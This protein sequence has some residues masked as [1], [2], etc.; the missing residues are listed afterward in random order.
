MPRPSNRPAFTLIELLVVMAIIAILIGLLLPAVQKVRDA[1]VGG[2]VMSLGLRKALGEAKEAGLEGKRKLLE[3]YLAE[4]D[5][6]RMSRRPGQRFGA[7]ARIHDAMEL[8]REVGLTDE[9]RLRARNI[10]IAALCL[11]DLQPGREWSVGDDGVWPD[12]LDPA[13]RRTARARAAF[14][15]V[16]QPRHALHG[17]GWTSPDGR[18]LAVSTHAVDWVWTRPIRVW[19]VDGAKQKLV[20]EQSE[21]VYEEGVAFRPDSREV[22][23]GHLSGAVSLHDLGTGKR[24]AQLEP[25]PG[26][27][28]T[29]A[30]HPRLPRL[31]VA[32][33]NEVTIW[34][35]Q[36]NRRLI[37]MPQPAAAIA[38]AWHPRGHRLAIA[39]GGHHIQLWDAEAGR[40]VTARWHG[41]NNDGT[42]LRFS[43]AGDRVFS[44]Q[45]YG[46]GRLWDAATGQLLLS[47]PDAWGCAFAEDD[48][49]LHPVEAT[50]KGRE[51]RVA[52]GQEMRA[53][54]R[55]TPRGPERV[56]NV[57]LHPGGR[58]LAVNTESGI[59]LF[60]LRS[61]DELDILPGR[62]AFHGG[63]QFDRNGDLWTAGASGLLR[64]PVRATSDSSRLRIGPPEWVADF[65][66]EGLE[67]FYMSDDAQVV[68]IGRHEEGALVIHR[69]TPP[70]P[71]GW[72]RS[73]T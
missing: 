48:K 34:D 37:R 52:G 20:L 47:L 51:L 56:R 10:A 57:S 22:A 6:K 14:D 36:T 71:C 58:L 13:A 50:R 5:A 11:P 28:F 43:H 17:H 26:P 68:S 40:P 7:L 42:Q 63:A 59:S 67:G 70:G 3:S 66:H 9:T 35:L 18:F 64:W 39:A 33:G 46:M 19:Q 15:R 27:V 44:T 45:W 54:Q 23:F 55:P 1:A 38:L 12:W 73:V 25:G 8:A 30:Y 2:V 72:G 62:F 24:V 29:L 16:P 53:F 4:A 49:S 21:G 60:D 41:H 31:A 65:M 32:S 61:G 69:R